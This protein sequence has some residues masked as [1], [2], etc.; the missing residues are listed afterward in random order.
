MSDYG[1]MEWLKLNRPDYPLVVE[2]VLTDLKLELFEARDAIR[3][4]YMK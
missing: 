2:S 3:A 1:A 4:E